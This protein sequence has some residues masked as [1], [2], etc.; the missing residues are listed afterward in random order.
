MSKYDE[1]PLGVNDEK[2]R[3]D[4]DGKVCRILLQGNGMALVE[5]PLCANC[6]KDA[7]RSRLVEITDPSPNLRKVNKPK[8]AKI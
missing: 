8:V 1:C 6:A 3:L 2:Q 7:R 4:P 5:Y